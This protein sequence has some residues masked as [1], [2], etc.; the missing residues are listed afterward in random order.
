MAS[1]G[2]PFASRFVGIPDEVLSPSQRR[3][4]RRSL[5]TKTDASDLANNTAKVYKV[6][7]ISRN[8]GSDTRSRIK[9]DGD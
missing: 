1:K 3:C 8:F 9:S 6:A 5:E 2:L 7:T 4:Q